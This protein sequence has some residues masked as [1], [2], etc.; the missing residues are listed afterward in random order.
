MLSDFLKLGYT[1]E[2]AELLNRLS[3]IG[4]G[5][6]SVNT[7]SPDEI[8]AALQ[9]VMNAVDDGCADWRNNDV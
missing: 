5:I 1:K 6:G 4:I 7:H 8:S 2:E 3:G 9:K